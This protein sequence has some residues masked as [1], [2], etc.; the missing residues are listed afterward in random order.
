M[1]L[2]HTSK[3]WKFYFLPLP[4]NLDKNINSLL[5]STKFEY[6]NIIFQKNHII[7]FLETILSSIYPIKQ[8]EAKM[9]CNV[10]CTLIRSTHQHKTLVVT[11]F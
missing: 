6:K 5:I 11:L 7:Y 10:F 2:R 1:S 8:I 9:I 4:Q 3:D